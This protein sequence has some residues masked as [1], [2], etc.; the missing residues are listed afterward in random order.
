MKINIHLVINRAIQ[1]LLFY[2][3]FIN[4][5]ESFFGPILA[6]FVL[7]NISGA[8]LQTVGFALAFFAV[9][10]AFVQIPVAR[11]LDTHVG[12][13]DDFYVLMAGAILEVLYPFAFL[14]IS[15]VWHLYL[16]ETMV[17]ISSGLLM[18]AYY[19]LFARHVD[20]GSEGLEWS[21]FSVWSLTLSGALGAALGG[22]IADT[23]GFQKLFL[24]SGL[25]CLAITF[26][27]P[28]LYP[29]LDGQRPRALPPFMPIPNN[30]NLKK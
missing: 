16:I 21:L 20:H 1:I 15:K 8:T 28:M 11:F 25:I 26:I 7:K 22:W 12:E 6:V 2:L 13:R 9:A 19:S 10:K 18:A 30:P 17:G 27:L 3:F 5:A 14:V 24:T 4:V 23:Y 29:L